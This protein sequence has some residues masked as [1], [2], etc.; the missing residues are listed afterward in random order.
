MSNQ[1]TTNEETEE[2]YKILS[3][4]EVTY[5]STDS[6]QIKSV[7]DQLQTYANNLPVFTNLLYKSLFINKIKEKPISLNL[8]KSAVIYIRN[9]LLKNSNTFKAEEIYHFI[10]NFSLVLFSWEKNENLNNSTI[11]TIL[12]NIIHFLLSLESI[13]NSP[14]FIENLFSDIAKILLENNQQYTN[15]KNIFIT[16]DKIIGLSSSLLTSKSCDTKNYENL[17]KKY[18]LPIVDKI[19][20]LGKKYINPSMNIYNPN[21][22]MIIKNLFDCIYNTLSYFKSFL[23]NELF[24]NINLYIFKT[25]WK[26]CQELIELCP[27]LDEKSKAKFG[28]QNPIIVLSIDEK[29]YNEINLMKSRVIQ[30]NCYLIQSICNISFD[31]DFK[32]NADNEINDKDLITFIINIIKLIVKSFEDLLS[33]KE[34]FYFVRNFE[35]EIFKDDNSIN[36]LLYELCVFLTRVLIRQP[37]KNTFR[38][39]IKLFLLN[40]L[41]PLF[42]TNDTERNQLE[43]FYETYHVYLDDI[44]EHFKIRN[45]RTS[46]IFLI[47]KI[48]NFF[49]DDNNFILSFSLEMFNYTINGGNINNEINY[50]IYLEN[51]NKFMI[52]KL[53]DETK[54]D[55]FLLLLLVLKDK[56]SNN[57]LFR[58]RLRELLIKNQLKLHQIQSLA[59]KIKICKLYSMYIPL[60]FKDEENSN[61]NIN[62][63]LSKKTLE[64][65]IYNNNKLNNEENKNKFPEEHYKFIQ[66][67]IDYLLKNISQ[68]ITL[69]NKTINKNNYYQSLSHVAAESISDLIISFKETTYE[70]NEENNNI[71]KQEN[72]KLTLVNQY[73]FKCLSEHFKIIINLILIIDNPSFY[74][75]IDYTL[76]NVKPKERED[77]FICLNN[78]TQKFIN[79]LNKNKDNE[80]ENTPF[81]VE[82][83][84]ILSDFLKGVNKLNKNDKK[85]IELFEEILNQVFNHININEL[86]KF[87]EN[88]ELIETIED[89]INLVE[90]INEKSIN[91]FKKVLPIIKK[92]NM[93]GNSLFSFLCTIMN[94]IPKT[95]N[96]D[97]KEKSKLID[98]IIEIIKISFTLN[99]ELYDNSVKH[100]LLLT[101]KLFNMCIN[102][103]PF[104]I[105]KELLIKS[106]NAFQ[107]LTKDDLYMGDITDKVVINQ[108]ILT[109]ISFG[110][111]FRPADTFKI[112]FENN[113][114]E[115]VQNK[116]KKDEN[117]DKDKD[118][119][120]NKDK[121]KENKCPYLTLFI[122]IILHDIGTANTDYIILLNKCI[123]LGLC[124]MFKEKYCL[125][126]LNKDI[127]IKILMLQIFAKLIEKH[128]KQQVEQLNKI[129]KKET[130]CNFIE[131]QENEDDEDD[132]DDEDLED[133]KETIQDILC[134]NK[135][136]KNAD[137][138]KYF[139]DIINEIKN[140]ENNIYKVLNDSSNGEL[141]ELLLIRNININY[142]GKEFTVPRKTVKI[143]KNKK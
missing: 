36:I 125:E 132:D 19:L 101:L 44:I 136:I 18:F 31:F 39:D 110:F 22:C 1:L 96:L 66:N 35:T 16:C 52:D 115:N 88:D 23:S 64:N 41:F 130:N 2:L 4:L 108:L 21:Y 58:N 128:K 94:Y 134:E 69:N 117:K 56:I 102:E 68:N 113:E 118:K 30:L 29:E 78:I 5:S 122:N 80:E 32:K 100:A 109:N 27:S 7:Q 50:N 89:Y 79:D 67:A 10:K 104:N 53:D 17:T 126:K 59:I 105:L 93:C 77:I 99:D 42:S 119:D 46:G 141:E 74:N 97:A 13:S 135:N 11:S 124:S 112:I 95:N 84:K 91:I 76:K 85:E 133:I 90:Y 87:E 73:I 43:K 40:I 20:G 70:E 140:N 55:L 75:L 86:E 106:L 54:I 61:I 24:K 139:C 123:I 15:E 127:N 107:P 72:E 6:S 114:I 63:F 143:I 14:T 65:N 33:N 111:I 12:Q 142:K 48:C 51:K 57:N 3:L 92:D 9:I 34:K 8:H 138:Y 98:E 81:I 28:S 103:I 129:M 37:F 71:I 82:Y 121:D 25:Y 83:F 62:N 47:S 49:P 38:N 116:E 137:E 45:F 26:Y 60:L 131:E 120:K